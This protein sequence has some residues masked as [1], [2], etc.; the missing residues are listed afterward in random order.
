MAPSGQS[1]PVNLPVNPGQPASCSTRTI[2]PQNRCSKKPLGQRYSASAREDSARTVQPEIQ[3]LC[4]LVLLDCR[5]SRSRA[6]ARKGL[7]G[8]SCRYRRSLASALRTKV[9]ILVP[10]CCK[11]PGIVPCRIDGLIQPGLVQSLQALQQCSIQVP[12][13]LLLGMSA[14]CSAVRWS[15]LVSNVCSSGQLNAQV[16]LLMYGCTAGVEH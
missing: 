10:H 11:V 16:W 12:D 6:R 14:D 2:R 3:W 8:E 7:G 1:N 15:A 13:V 9:R 4:G 5:V